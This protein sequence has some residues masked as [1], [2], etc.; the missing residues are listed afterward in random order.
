[1]TPIFLSRL[2]VYV[3][4]CITKLANGNLKGGWWQVIHN[5]NYVHNVSGEVNDRMSMVTWVIAFTHAKSTVFRRWLS[6]FGNVFARI[7][8]TLTRTHVRSSVFFALTCA[9]FQSV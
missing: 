6:Y 4:G 1:M 5:I 9:I 3:G 2:Y 7:R 8:A